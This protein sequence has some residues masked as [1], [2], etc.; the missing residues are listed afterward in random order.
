MCFF[1]QIFW[2]KNLNDAKARYYFIS[3]G[4]FQVYES[5]IY[6]NKL[7]NNINNDNNM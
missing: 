4:S 3:R 6:R 2:N 5:Y 1:L 7:R